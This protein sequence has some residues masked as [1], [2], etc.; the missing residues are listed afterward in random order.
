[1]ALALAAGLVLALSGTARGEESF[2]PVPVGLSVVG[3]DR[4]QATNDFGLFWVNPVGSQVL[5]A[6]WQA[7]GY[8]DLGPFQSVGSVG[9]SAL[10]HV[11]V[12]AAGVWY[13]TV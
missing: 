9:I 10:D 2:P 5:G 1:M 8:E 12:P 11:R 4:W 3:G 13:L 6:S 7:A